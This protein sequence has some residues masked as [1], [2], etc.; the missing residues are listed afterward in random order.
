MIVSLK[1]YKI[2]KKIFFIKLTIN[3]ESI[4]KSSLNLSNIKT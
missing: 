1:D 4:K 2:I 3:D